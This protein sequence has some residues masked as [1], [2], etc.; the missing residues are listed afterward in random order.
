MDMSGFKEQEYDDKFNAGLWKSIIHF[1]KPYKKYA[2]KLFIIMVVV[3]F[4]DAVQ[5]IITKMLIDNVILTGHIDQILPIASVYGVLIIIQ[6]LN[7]YLLISTAGRIEMGL[8]YEIRKAGFNR[9]QEL[10]FSYYDKT[11]LGW[12]MS[13]MTS[14]IGKLSDTISWGL[15]DLTW[16]LFMMC[17]IMISLFYHNVKL[18]LVTLSVLPVLIVISIYFQRKILKSYRKVRKIN[19]QITGLFSEGIMGAKTTKTLVIEDKNVAHFKETTQSMNKHSVRAATFSALYLPLVLS[20]GSIGTAL[21][22]VYGGYELKTGSLTYGSLVMFINYTVLFFNP[23]QDLARVMAEIQ[24][25]QASAE[26]IISLIQTEP[27]ITDIKAL[28]DYHGMLPEIKGNIHFKN[29]SFEYK[30]GEDVLK[31]FDLDIKAGQSIALVG[32]TGS[33]KSTIVNLACR[34]YEPTSG[35]IL[36]DG[37]D[38]RLIPQEWIHSNLGYVLQSPHLFSGS[39]RDNIAYGKLDASELEIIRASKLV[40][41]HEFIVKLPDGYD[42]EVGEGGCNLST[43]Q[44]QLLSFARAILAN[45]AI[46]VLDEA[47]SSIDTETEALIQNA[48]DQVLKDR[49][50]FIV[51]HRLSTIRNADKIIVLRNGVIQEM[52]THKELMRLKGYYYNLY[53]NQFIEENESKLLQ[54]NTPKK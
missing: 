3:A 1:G 25:S 9:L 7:A 49:T 35:E 16:A 13:R 41:A 21:A 37:M 45:P 29:V 19:S 2:I 36:F 4:I 26:R 30:S 42:T 51:A 12:I 22:L 48:I 10:S 5:P 27:E 28:E 20:L 15:V 8:N 18:A 46:F 54:K 44:K 32:E 40:R 50:S 33:G 34:F 11:P 24:N 14:D 6:G 31:N 17:F 38:Y 52:G 53:T 39:I 47:T 43:G 23:I